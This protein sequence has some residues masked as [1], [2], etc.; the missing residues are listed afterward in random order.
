MS[1]ETLLDLDSNNRI[2]N[3]VGFNS[4]YFKVFTTNQYRQTNT[5]GQ[6]KFH[7]IKT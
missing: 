2:E 4:V 5:D 6:T 3:I 7:F 1:T